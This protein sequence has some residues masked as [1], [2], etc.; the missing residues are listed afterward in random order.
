MSTETDKAAP[1][2][3]VPDK[4]VGETPG[5]CK[6][7]GDHSHAKGNGG[8][9]GHSHWMM[10]ACCVPMLLVAGVLLFGGAGLASLAPLL[11]CVAMMGLMMVG[12]SRMHRGG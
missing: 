1:A 10:I 5:C 8:G 7:G 9:H 2:V 6:G 3:E 4:G 12:M 11:L